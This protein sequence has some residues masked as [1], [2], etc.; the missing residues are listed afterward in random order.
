MKKL[1]ILSLLFFGMIHSFAQDNFDLSTL[2]I[3][4]FTV[5]MKDKAAEQFSKTKLVTYDGPNE[6]NK[7]NK[8]NY[9]G[10]IIEI[11]IMPNWDDVGQK[12]NGYQIYSLS[13]KSKKFRTKSGMGVGSTK[14]QLIDAYR[15]YPNFSVNQM[16]D[17]KTEKQ[18]SAMSS[19][20]L[21]DNDAGTYLSFTLTNN[22][23]T[24]VSI[25]MNEGC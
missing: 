10:E 7:K 8:V 20:V 11:A 24:E 6:Y 3:G 17:E 9:N 14:D 12:E 4:P 25:Y 19:F 1:L 16:W 23:V 18:S 2:R 13:T 22:I 21:T 5:F 15:N